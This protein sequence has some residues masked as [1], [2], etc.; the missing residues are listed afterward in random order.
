[1]STRAI[2]TAFEA[3]RDSHEAGSLFG[4]VVDKELWDRLCG[5]PVLRSKTPSE[6]TSFCLERSESVNDM[7]IDMADLRIRGGD[8]VLL[9]SVVQIRDVPYAFAYAYF[10]RDAGTSTISSPGGNIVLNNN[11]VVPRAVVSD[12][13]EWTPI[14]S[15][16]GEKGHKFLL[17]NGGVVQAHIEVF[18]YDDENASSIN[19]VLLVH[20]LYSCFA[21]VAKLIDRHSILE[22]N[23]IKEHIKKL[24]NTMSSIDDDSIYL[25]L[26]EIIVGESLAPTNPHSLA[27]TVPSHLKSHPHAAIAPGVWENTK[28]QLHQ[29]SSVATNCIHQHNTEEFT[30]ANVN[31]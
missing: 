20:G 13:V 4:S 14:L 6:V 17:S 16:C 29:L 23:S 31:Y 12:S 5:S 22:F 1:M 28:T 10:E 18:L 11:P 9:D 24:H 7:E 27:T 26:N 2:A 15:S 8:V 25:P 21:H 3:S 19:R 30:R